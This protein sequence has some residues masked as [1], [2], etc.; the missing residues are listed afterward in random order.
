MRPRNRRA[1]HPAF[2]RNHVINSEGGIIEEEYRVEYVAD[3][4]HTTATVFLGLSMQCAR[5]HD[6]KFDPI[7]QRD[8]YGFFALFNNVP[9]TILAIGPVTAAAPFVQAPSP[10]QLADLERLNEQAKTLELRR[11]ARES[12]I[13]EPL[14]HWELE[15]VAAEKTL[16]LP[17]G[18]LARLA[19]DETAGTTTHDSIDPSR[20]GAIIGDAKWTSGKLG[21]ALEFDGKTHVDLHQLVEFDLDRSF[22]IG[23]WIYL[24]SLEP[25]T[26]VSKMDESNAYRGFDLI[27]EQ[28]KPAMHLIHHWPDIGLK[29]IAKSPISLNTW[30]HVVATYDG[31]AHA[32]GVVIHVDGTAQALDISSDKL[33]STIKTDKPVHLGRRSQTA[34][35][36]GQIDEVQFYSKQLSSEDVR[37][38]ANGQPLPAL[39][40]TIALPGSPAVC[41]AARTTTPILSR[42]R[43]RTI[44][45]ALTAE[46][47][48]VMRKQRADFENISA[49]HGHGGNV[50]S[51]PGFLAQARTVR[52][53]WRFRRAGSARQPATTA[54][55]RGREPLGP[56][57]VVGGS[58]T[59]LRPRESPS[60]AGGKCF[61]ARELSRRSRT[62]VPKVPGR[63]IPNCW[64]GWRR[65]SIA[66]GWNVKELQK[67]I[68]MS[69]TYR[70][71]SHV[72]PELLE[73][74][75]KN[76]LLARGSR[77]RLSAETVRDNALAIS[78]LLVERLGGPSVRPYQPDGLWQD[79]SV[80]RRAVYTPEVGENLY[81][82][83]LYTFWKRTCPPP[84]LA[85]FDAPDRETCLIRRA[86]TNT[87]LQALVLM[88]DPT[89]VEAARKLAELVLLEAGE[90]PE[91]RL[92]HAFRLA[93]SRV[94]RPAEK[95]VL[96][97]LLD[98]A[99]KRFRVM[100]KKADALLGVG[101]AAHNTLLD[102]VELAAWTTVTSVIM[103][104]DETISKE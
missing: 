65:N 39:A 87:P 48:A 8:Y 47:A 96:L 63:P 12:Q 17:A 80:D 10:I 21:N 92:D 50:H 66:S 59:S 43:R 100:P 75:P 57:Q 44:S 72:A 14:A 19:L 29:T 89:Y 33:H 40:E 84:S 54:Q 102:A 83:S 45:V 36:H 3:R 60:I 70:Q 31:T 99:T 55:R 93:V 95:E 35:F 67:L 28:G 37:Q 23:S 88:N 42:Q 32:S 22:S 26:V 41:R 34:P 76:Q 62:L 24:T 68:V 1:G 15:A 78:G 79:V 61:S 18:L 73:R 5:C 27:I 69:A 86:R 25:C 58:R 53:A 13:D 97:P 85:T 16:N 82:R 71:S 49:D 101:Q 77:F 6:H 11:K 91:S 74:D 51:T 2:C 30:H 9:E 52:P 98:E 46:L 4:V 64:I 81:R 7:T 56:C 20:A 94:A 38:L 90:A 104:L 103:N